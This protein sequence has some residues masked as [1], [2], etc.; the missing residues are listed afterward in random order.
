MV[1][2]KTLLKKRRNDRYESVYIKLKD[3]VDTARYFNDIKAEKCLSNVMA[4]FKQT[5]KQEWCNEEHTTIS[6]KWLEVKYTEFN[7]FINTMLEDLRDGNETCIETQLKCAEKELLSS[8]IDN[9]IE[10]IEKNHRDKY[11]EA[12]K[13]LLRLEKINKINK[14]ENS[15]SEFQK[16]IKAC[17]NYNKRINRMD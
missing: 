13:L 6:V 8:Y 15:L 3:Y 11:Y 17:L 12:I 5:S 7:N 16:D 1:S 2:K 10:Y 4:R 9:N 14:M